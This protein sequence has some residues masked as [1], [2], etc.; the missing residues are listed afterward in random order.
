MIVLPDCLILVAAERAEDPA[1]ESF[2]A[3]IYWQIPF[4]RSSNMSAIHRKA[5]IQCRKVGKR[6]DNAETLIGKL[7]PQRLP[8][9]LKSAAIRLAS[10]QGF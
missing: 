7:V 9:I 4:V 2:A 3:K 8:S 6:T 1:E 10:S 5:E